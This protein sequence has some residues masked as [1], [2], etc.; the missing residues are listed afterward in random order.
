MYVTELEEFH[1]WLID[2]KIN[3]HWDKFSKYLDNRIGME[4][5]LVMTLLGSVSRE[6]LE[7][8]NALIEQRAVINVLE[9]MRELPLMSAIDIAQTIGMKTD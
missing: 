2:Q 3:G 8:I 5:E 6:N 4:K 1:S 7:A 9:E